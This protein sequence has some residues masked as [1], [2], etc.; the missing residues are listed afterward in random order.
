M[1]NIGNFLTKNNLRIKGL[2]EHVEGKDFKSFL[3]QLFLD[4]AGADS[5]FMV[6][7]PTA[8]RIGPQSKFGTTKGYTN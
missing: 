8:F 6:S 7:N 1:E 3:E 2:K 5:E 4:L